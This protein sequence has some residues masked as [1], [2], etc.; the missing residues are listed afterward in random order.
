MDV[1]PLHLAPKKPIQLIAMN[2]LNLVLELDALLHVMTIIMVLEAI[3]T[4][5]RFYHFIHSLLVS[6]NYPM[7]YIKI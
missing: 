7:T 4:Q 1:A 3:L 6:G 2:E 5:L